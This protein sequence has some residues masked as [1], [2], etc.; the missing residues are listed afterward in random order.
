MRMPWTKRTETRSA[1][2]GYSESLSRLIEA[3]ATGSTQQ[4]TATAAMEAASG[5]LSRAFVS[6]TVTGPD[7]VVEAVN[8]RFLAQVGRDLIRV[9]ESLHVIRYTGGRLALLPSSTWYWQGEADPMSWMATA[10]VYGPTGSQTWRLPM[11]SVIF[12]SWGSPTSRPYHGLGPAQWAAETGRLAANA[13]RSLANEAGGP[14]AQMLTVPKDG[15]DGSD[16]VDPMLALKGDISKAKGGALLL[17]TT[18]NNWGDGRAGAPQRDWAASRLGPQPP[19]AMVS[20]ADHAFGRLLA[21][22]GASPAL[23]DD[24]DGTSKRE[25]LRQWHLGTVAPLA[26]MLATELSMK[27]DSEVKLA[28]DLY[29]IDLSGRAMAFQKLVGQGVDIERALAITGLLVCD[30]E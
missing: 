23:F 11:S 20:L 4:A 7:D 18:Q 15:G 8:P 25:A 2:S 12:A 13:E 10:T 19:E 5:A 27:L 26:K 3:Q 30:D 24:S 9:G 14:L 17:E 22:C 28:F 16:D 1:V 21:A 6:A 29:N